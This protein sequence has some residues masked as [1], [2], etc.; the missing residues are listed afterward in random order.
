M[1]DF[2]TIYVFFVTVK[3]TVSIT[4][5]TPKTNKE[6]KLSAEQHLIAELIAAISGE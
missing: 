5:S 2:Q 6:I 4:K 3:F 1:E